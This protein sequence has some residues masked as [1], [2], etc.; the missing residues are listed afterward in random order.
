MPVAGF[1]NEARQ[2]RTRADFP[3]DGCDEQL[4]RNGRSF[5]DLSMSEKRA[6]HTCDRCAQTFPGD[7]RADPD[8]TRASLILKRPSLCILSRFPSSPCRC[9]S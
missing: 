3:V 2:P 5:I 4:E 7:Q 1:L 6:E 8:R 9:G